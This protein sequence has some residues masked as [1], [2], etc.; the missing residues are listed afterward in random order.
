MLTTV[1]AGRYNDLYAAAHLV[2]LSSLQLVF[3]FFDYPLS[4]RL[5]NLTYAIVVFT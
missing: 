2:R 5:T 3:S 1:P 4:F